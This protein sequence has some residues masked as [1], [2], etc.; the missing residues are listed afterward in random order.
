VTN[1]KTAS[2]VLVAVLAVGCGSAAPSTAPHNP[3]A[4]RG[5]SLPTAC[6]VSTAN[7]SCG[8]YAKYTSITGT[9]S[10]TNIGNNVWSPIS[11]WGQTLRAD[12]PGNWAVT[13]NMPAGNTAVVSYPSVGANYGQTSGDAEP[14]SDF[15]SLYSSF[16]ENM[17]ATSAT[18][19]WAA[20]DIWLRPS[21]KPKATEEVMIQHDFANNGA[22]TAEASATFGGSAG[23]PVQ[24][25]NLC[26][27]GS[28]LVWKL[29]G[30]NEQSGTV[31]ILAM[32]NWLVAHRYLAKDSGLYLI[33]YGWEICSTG[34]QNENFEVSRFSITA[35]Y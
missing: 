22:C 1:L 6:T 33:G 11:G 25:W 29:T 2:L 30:G 9:T 4:S 26:Q 17:N 32:L 14:L 31:D 35:K 21:S 7:G 19:A 3:L 28:E 15:S 23:V 5:A 16:S 27:F 10:A 8:P 24:K 34:G 13:A 18:S 20:Y 12:N